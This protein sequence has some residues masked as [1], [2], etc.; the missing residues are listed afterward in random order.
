MIDTTKVSVKYQ[1][2]RF[3]QLFA[4]VFDHSNIYHQLVIFKINSWRLRKY[5]FHVSYHSS[6]TFF[7]PVPSDLYLRSFV[8]G[9]LC[10]FT[11]LVSGSTTT[12]N[13]MLSKSIT[14]HLLRMINTVATTRLYTLCGCT[15][16]FT[17]AWSKTTITA[18]AILKPK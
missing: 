4:T 11:K 14:F 16:S 13:L 7:E 18:T 5:V 8:T 6:K 10:R 12:G 3:E 1:N 15:S 17:A 9:P 2:F